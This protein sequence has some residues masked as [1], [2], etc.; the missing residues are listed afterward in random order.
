MNKY[1]DVCIVGG[2]ASGL[3][4]A[5]YI[6]QN[7]QNISVLVLERLSRVGKKLINTGNGRCNITNKDESFLHYHG[8]NSSFAEYSVS[9]YSNKEIE[10]FFTSIGVS[11]IY[12]DKGRGYPASLQASSVVD[13]LRFSAEELGVDIH[14]NCLFKDFESIDNEY[15]IKT[16]DGSVKAEIIVFAAGLYSGGVRM[17]C[18][19]SV[20]NLLKAKGE[21]CVFVSPAIAQVKTNNEFTRQLKG[22]K[23]NA[24]AELFINE[25]LIRQESGEVLFCDYGLSGP[26]IL[27]IA[28]EIERQIGKKVIKLDLIPNNSFDEIIDLLKSLR[29]HLSYRNLDEYLSGVINKRLGQV[30][31]KATGHK[32]S[33]KVSDLSDKDIND[34]AKMLKSFSFT[35]I[36]T[37]GFDNSQVT[38][39]G[40]DTNS[41]D[42]KT[43]MS[44]THKNM[45]AIGEILDIDGDCGGYNLHFAFSSAFCCVDNIIKEYKDAKA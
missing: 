41:F 28:R 38:A 10:H 33:E 6:K 34:V 3:T 1:Y 17:G 36:S 42:D 7:N 39:G 22:V 26:P 45:Y 24:V 29:F 30:I 16:D 20:F 4:A 35:A 32:L 21:Q 11:I 44:K 25:S 19:G 13:A 15:V 14:T 37:T 27:Q 9:K 43:M 40:L 8:N 12:D 2:G 18:D 31:I 23:V 5:V